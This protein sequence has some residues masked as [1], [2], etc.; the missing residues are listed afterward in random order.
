VVDDFHG[1]ETDRKA[2]LTDSSLL[3]LRNAMRQLMY[4]YPSPD[5]AK[6]AVKEFY[7]ANKHNVRA[8]DHMIQLSIRPEGLIK[9]QARVRQR[10]DAGQMN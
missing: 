8:L 10:P 4:D 2:N 6:F 9:Y 7:Q 1:S 5:S 3:K